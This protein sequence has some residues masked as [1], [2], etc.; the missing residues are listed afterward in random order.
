MKIALANK[1]SEF[2]DVDDD[3]EN[4]LPEH[5]KG[6]PW[7]LY[8][9]IEGKG[10]GYAGARVNVD[11]KRK[12]FYLHRAIMGLF[13]GGRTR[14]ALQVIHLNHDKLDNQRANLAIGTPKQNAATS[15]PKTKTG[16]KGVFKEPNGTYTVKLGDKIIATGCISVADANQAA[17]RAALADPDLAPFWPATGITDPN[18]PRLPGMEENT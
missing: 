6:A 4:G 16:C 9:N 14:D 8:R 18:C 17:E 5:L 2:T 15:P 1:P 12:F 13:S 3:F 10:D 11:G 7:G